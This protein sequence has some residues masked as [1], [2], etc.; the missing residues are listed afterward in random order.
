MAEVLAGSGTALGLLPTGTA[1]LLARNLALVA[2][3]PDNATRIALSGN[4]RAVDVGWV[5]ADDRPGEQVFLVM[6]GMGFDAAIM[7]GA[8]PEPGSPSPWTV[9]PNCV[10][11]SAR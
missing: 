3:D 2:D 9:R 4:N 6:A 1:N 10:V 11:E 5:L 7:A 8:S